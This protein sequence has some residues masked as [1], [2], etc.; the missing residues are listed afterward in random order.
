[1]PSVLAVFMLMTSSNFVGCSMG[2]SFGCYPFR[3]RSTNFA[4]SRT[5][6]GPSAPNAIRP[7]ISANA[8]AV[9]G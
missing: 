8:R 4:P 2:M 1:M 5:V 3:I 6:V 7:P 9:D